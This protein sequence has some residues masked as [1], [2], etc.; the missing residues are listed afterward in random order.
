M[1][2]SLFPGQV[3]AV[4]GMNIS[5][6][7]M[8][9]S[10]IFCGAA[11][12][13]LKTKASELIRFHYDLQ[14]SHPLKVMAVCG[15]YTTCDNLEYAPLMDLIEIVRSQKPD[16]VIMMGPFVR[17]ANKE[18]TLELDDGSKMQVTYEVF[19]ANKFSALVEEL[20]EKETDLQT[21]FVL[22]PCLDDAVAEWVFPQAPLENRLGNA[23]KMINL[24]GAEGIEF[25]TLGL[26]HIE[27][28]GRKGGGPRRVY[29]VSNPC[30]LRIN[31][32]VV[33]ITSNDTIFQMSA[34]ETNANLVPGS[35]LARIAQHLLEQQSYYPLFPPPLGTNLDLRQMK[36]CKMPCRP[37]VLI[38]PSKLTCFARTVCDTTMVVNPGHLVKGSTGGTY[39]VIHLHPMQRETVEN[40]GSDEVELV[41]AIQDRMSI[42]IK[43]I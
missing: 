2:Y 41:H 19:F 33:G 7:K 27:N 11:P 4:E 42:E 6:R 12:A 13:P 16:V 18:T 40:A 22:A 34:D 14:D 37:D 8:V 30:T 35:R 23:G 21:Q 3:V 20:F 38:L 17:V 29:C 5:G 32:V 26:H 31:E 28:A 15:P 43:R 1:P 24:P 36:Y 9:P 25:G 10:R 39:A